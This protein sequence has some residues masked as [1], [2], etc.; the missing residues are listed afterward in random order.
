MTFSLH[1]GGVVMSSQ[2]SYHTHTNTP[3]HTHM[4]A[5]IKIHSLAHIL[6]TCSLIFSSCV[7]F[8]VYPNRIMYRH[9]SPLQVLTTRAQKSGPKEHS[10]KQKCIQLHM[11]QGSPLF[12]ISRAFSRSLHRHSSVAEG[13]LHTIQPA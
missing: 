11:Y 1:Q 9:P 8:T 2:I 12:P 13:Y 6:D 10:A 4:Q 5:Y 7:L 3:T